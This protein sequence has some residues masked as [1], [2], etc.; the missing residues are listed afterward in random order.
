[1]MRSVVSSLLSLIL[2]VTVLLLAGCAGQPPYGQEPNLID[3]EPAP[4]TVE[5][6]KNATYESEFVKAGQ[7]Q[8]KDG[9]YEEQAAPDS[10][11][12]NT[13]MLTEHVAFGDVN[14]DPIDDAAVVLAASG[15]GSGTF[16]TLAI[17]INRMGNPFHFHT[18]S[19]GDRIKVE[20]VEIEDA[21]I[22]V[23]MLVHGEGDAMCCPTQPEVRRYNL[24]FGVLRLLERTTPA[25]R[26]TED[27]LRNATYQHEF[28][29]DGQAQLQDGKYEEAI[30]GS[31]S[32][33]HIALMDVV[34]LGDL[35]GDG[36]WDAAV[37]LEAS[38]G[39]SGTF[40]SL[41]AVINEDGAPVHVASVLLGDRVQ[42][43]ELLIA[44]Q[45]IRVQMVTHGQGD[46][47]CCP[48][49]RVVHLYQLTDEGLELRHQEEKGKV[50]NSE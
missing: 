11:S 28:P 43:E 39:G 40:R 50:G 29:K 16:Y 35:N 21:V 47:L 46:A 17:V 19:L 9:V 2:L 34:A 15:G 23:R 1:M 25:G 38:G 18:A 3:G 30:E 20:A 36:I 24:G 4:L 45:Y 49:L 42:I 7:A 44:D 14:G 10:A 31:A 32:K 33:I 12:K 48:T 26:L 5:V 41:E 37:V 22:T 27:A 8:L 13:L 6:L